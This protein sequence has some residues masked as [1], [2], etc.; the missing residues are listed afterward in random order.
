MNAQDVKAE[1]QK[2]ADSRRAETGQSFFKTGP[3]Q[4]GEGD[5]FIGLKVPDT[6]A[7]CKQY[8]DLPLSEIQRLLESPIHEHRL[9]ALVIMTLQAKK[10]SPEYKKQLYDFYLKNTAHIN[11]W[12]LVDL[13]CPQ[14]VGA[15]LVDK[16]KEP[17][18]KLAHSKD[19]WE[20][21]LAMV[22]TLQL[23][24]AGQLGDTFAI[25]EILLHDKHDLIHKAV[26]WMLRCAG[27]VDRAELLKF[28]DSRAHK[29]PRTALRYALEHLTPAQKDHYMNL[30][31]VK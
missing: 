31:S 20:K 25:A 19:L 11:N 23:I 9:A 22:S 1:L 16:P 7:V 2:H 4:Y 21:R 3:G 13:S 15:Y 29:M 26:G 12:D 24:R 28:L 27:D 6:R 18:Y 10:T 30:K 17:L 5:K 14:I 8:K